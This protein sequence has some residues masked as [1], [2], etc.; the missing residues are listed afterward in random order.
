MRHNHIAIWVTALLQVALGF[1]W[2]S[3]LAF[4]EPWAYGFGLDLTVMGE[5]DPVALIVVV[6]GAVVNCYVVSWLIRR[7]A[8]TGVGG[9]VWLALWLWLGL[10]LPWLMPHYLFAKVGNSALIVD[11]A[12]LLVAT[13]MT[14]L[15]LALWRRKPRTIA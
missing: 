12:Q 8:I 10:G 14:C 2:Y 5:P 1:L 6:L 13:S 15:I 7:M 9:A 3:P 11:A 4:L